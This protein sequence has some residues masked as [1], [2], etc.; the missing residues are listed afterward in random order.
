MYYYS[1]THYE[2]SDICCTEVI[3]CSEQPFYVQVSD[4]IHISLSLVLTL[5]WVT[6]GF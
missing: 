1:N 4:M 5:G 6:K 2:N 3:T